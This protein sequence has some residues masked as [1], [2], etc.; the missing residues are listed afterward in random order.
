MRT[1]RQSLLELRL[2]KGVEEI[3]TDALAKYAGR[4]HLTMLVGVDLGVSHST[5]HNWCSQF[6]ID[7]EHF[8]RPK[9]EPAEVEAQAVV[10]DQTQGVA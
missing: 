7:L 5:V 9:T 2:G 8:R 4:P 3:L 6:R 10:D 1:D